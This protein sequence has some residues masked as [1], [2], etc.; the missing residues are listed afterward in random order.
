MAHM[1]K[2]KSL[3]ETIA[4]G[5]TLGKHL[6]AG[7]KIALKGTLGI[8]KTQLVRGIAHTYLKADVHVCSPS[9]TIINPYEAMG[10]LIYH[11]DLYRLSTIEEVESTGYWD[12]I[13]DPDA[14]VLMEWLEQVDQAKPIDF[15]TI[16]ITFE[17]DDEDAEL[18]GLPRCFSLQG[19][20][21]SELYQRLKPLFDPETP[22][23]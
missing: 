3:D 1:I 17:G 7:D 10:R 23:T 6:K 5:E 4:F 16:A 14:L 12:C 13:E 15:V 2:T 9:F 20:A 22:Q 18:S 19:P 8:G 11:L 21:T